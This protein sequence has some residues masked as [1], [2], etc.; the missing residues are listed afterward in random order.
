MK[1]TWLMW[2][3][4]S[5]GA[6]AQVQP[7]E[8]AAAPAAPAHAI[9][10][11]VAAG[12]QRRGLQPALPCSD[13]VFVRRVHLD[14]IGTLPT[15][16][17]VRA[18]LRDRAADKRAVLIEALLQRPEYATYQAMRWCELLRVKAEFPINLW[19]NAVQ[20]F[21]RW[22]ED[23]LRADLPF[24]Q[25][26]RAMLLATGSNFR[27]PEVNF[28]RAAPDRTPAGLARIVAL[29]FLG[30]R[31]D[32]WP[33]A[34]RQG[35]ERCFAK[36]AFKPTQEWKEEIVYCDLA[37]SVGD[38]GR[39]PFEITLPDG[40]RRRVAADQDP[41]Q[42]FVDWLLRDDNPVLA[43]VLCNRVWY[44]LCGVGIVHEPD[45]FRADNPAWSQELLDRLARELVAGGLRPKQLFRLLLNSATWQR[46]AIPAGG[47]AAGAG[48]AHYRVRRLEAEVLI[49]AIDQVTG[50]GEEYQSPIPEPFSFLP[51]D[52]R[53]IAIAD[54]SVTSAF[55]ELFGRPPRDTGLQLER[56][57]QPTAA[58]RLH[59]LNSSHLLQK[60]QS[61]RLPGLGGPRGARGRGGQLERAVEELYLTILSRRPTAAELDAVR[62]HA[63]GSAGNPRQVAEDLAWALLN[64]SEFLYRH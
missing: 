10:Q 60:L 28:L 36:V 1:R 21:H 23:C 38:A 48:F 52:Q 61:G 13:E 9:D 45:D 64:S 39:G 20:A 63:E 11:L 35:L 22:I 7:F 40:S 51:K 30:A 31:I 43:Q 47:D 6:L 4:L 34:R 27:Q 25:F 32:S 44:W 33:E 53:A 58:Q 14:L 24:D 29:T 50:T 57:E 19:P 16:A 49:D 12:L 54:G 55:L 17:E 62:R 46:S 3:W 2:L 26:A 15:A 5:G 41:R 18:F 42:V 8:T 59:L 37:A 56:Q